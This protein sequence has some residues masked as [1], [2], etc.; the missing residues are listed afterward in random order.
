[1]SNKHTEQG[2]GERPAIPLAS[3]GC[4]EPGAGRDAERRHR[5][6]PAP[7]RGTASRAYGARRI[8]RKTGGATKRERV[9]V[10]PAEKTQTQGQGLDHP[11]TTAIRTRFTRL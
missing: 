11:V 2:G 6:D 10:A 3:L 1:M 5:A 8:D 7:H 9:R 4:G